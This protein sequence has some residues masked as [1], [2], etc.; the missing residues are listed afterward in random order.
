M[1]YQQAAAGNQQQFS[2]SPDLIPS[3]ELKIKYRKLDPYT[4]GEIKVLLLENISTKAVKI[5][6]D[7]GF[8]VKIIG[9]FHLLINHRRWNLA[10][11]R[12]RPKS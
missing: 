11:R 3:S 7:S 4:S 1:H 10:K 5:F 12:F 6:Q 2:V 9:L 8:H